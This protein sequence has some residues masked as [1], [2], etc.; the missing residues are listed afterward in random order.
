MK[1][2]IVLFLVFIMYSCTS[3][4][5]KNKAKSISAPTETAAADTSD[6]AKT[7]EEETCQ[8]ND[9][10]ALELY[11]LAL[12]DIKAGK[13]TDAKLKIGQALEREPQFAK[14]YILLGE[15]SYKSNPDDALRQY[16]KSLQICSNNDAVLFYKMAKLYFSKRDY[17]K[18][19]EKF[20][21]FIDAG[22]VK[23]E[24]TKVADSLIE[25]C[26]FY[27]QVLN[28][29]VPFDPH[30]VEG[31][32][33]TADEYLPIISPDNEIIL[34]TRK[35]M[36][37]A[38]KFS[39]FTGGKLVEEFTL[40]RKSEG[41]FDRGKALPPP[42]NSGLN[43]GGASLTIDNKQMYL[44]ICNIKG[45]MGSCDLWTTSYK[46][47]KWQ[48]MQNLGSSVNDSM[49][50]SQASVSS[51][52]KTVYYSSDMPGGFG[53]KD[54]YKIVKDEKGYFG[55][56]I[57]LGAAINTSG[58]EKSPF[59]HVDNKTLYFCSNGHL[60]LGGFDIF[61]ARTDSNRAWGKPVNIGSPINS[62]KDDLGFFVSTD[63]KKGYFASNKM[64]GVGGWD[65]YSFDLYSAARPQK[66]I[67]MKGKIQDDKGN[68]VHDATMELK[69]L[70]TNDIYKVDIDS[71]G[72]Y[73]FAHAL[74][75]DQMVLV[76]KEG[77]FYSSQTIKTNDAKMEGVQKL[78]FNIE[79]VQQGKSYKIKNLFF[80]NNSSLLNED[81][82]LELINLVVFM[83]GTPDI[84]IEIAGHT[85]NVGNDQSNIEL[86]A[87]RAKAVYTFLIENG[88]E[89]SR[90][91]Y[92]GYGKNKPIA[93]NTT[94][95][96]RAANRRTEITIL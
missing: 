45:G 63:G 71:N 62:D 4:A 37:Q 7:D 24:W 31:V 95:T 80:E 40:S 9:K 41:V 13:S 1:K 84:S 29:P 78:N 82:K 83:Q 44:T 32:N 17:V 56:P 35:Y 70:K 49:W 15:L 27:D 39:A 72:E 38:D 77:Y 94:E 74:D 33:T 91:R 61:Y 67:L 42:F 85:D 43:E 65:I 3:L 8:I 68:A 58:D 64:Q 18:A 2:N 90:L 66:V 92:K 11:E 12:K 76:K 50:Q 47:D 89:S 20:S 14:A 10:K 19:K 22:S 5:Q 23:P 6:N 36:K 69:D 30:P 87:Q 21:A 59:I 96:G 34:F 79:E 54:I 25:V 28:N 73:V 53:G 81:A 60:G 55:E 57:N 46:N 48:M 51:D 26:T 16:E 75:N 52:G 88:I 86:S 93:D